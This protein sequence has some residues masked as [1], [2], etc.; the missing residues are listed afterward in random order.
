MLVGYAK[1]ETVEPLKTLGMYLAKGI[2]GAFLLFLGFLFLALGVLRLVQSETGDRFDGGG[3][4]SMVPYLAAILTLVVLMIL[5]YVLF[6]RA[7]ERVKS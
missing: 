2:A 6:I 1:Q 3:W 5:I 7:K 4:G